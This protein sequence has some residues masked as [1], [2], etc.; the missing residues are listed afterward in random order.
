MSWSAV[1]DVQ[2]P[3]IS[4]AILAPFQVLALV[5]YPD[6][7]EVSGFPEDVKRKATEILASCRGGSAGEFTFFSHKKSLKQHCIPSV[8]P[9]NALPA[10]SSPSFPSLAHFS[11]LSS[12]KAATVP[13]T[14]SLPFLKTVKNAAAR[15]KQDE[16]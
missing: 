2:R 14:A 11:P 1:H 16:K 12:T 8:D 13:V 7:I 6:L 15:D 4:T 9:P 10:P 5:S 3:L